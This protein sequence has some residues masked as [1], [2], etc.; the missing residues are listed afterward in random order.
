MLFTELINNIADLYY[1][2]GKGA[3]DAY[4]LWSRDFLNFLHVIFDK[5]F[6]VFLGIAVAVSIL[7]YLISIYGLFAKKKQEDTIPE[8]TLWPSVTVQI[9]TYNELA[10]LNCA[11][12]CLDFE[13]PKEKVQIIMGD[14]SN[15]PEISA[16]IKEFCDANG[17]LVAKRESNVGFKPGNL[18][19]MLKYSTGDILVLFDSD[20]LP[21][22]DFL[23]RIIYPMTKDSS[24]SAVQARWK[25][26][27]PNTN[28]VTILGATM[29]KTF[30]HLI[31]PFVQKSGISFLCGSAEAIKKSVLL[32]L[33]GWKSGSLTEDIECSLRMHINGNKLKYLET[34][35]CECEVPYT[36]K[37]IYKQQMRWAYG[38][39][40]AFKTHLF[41]VLKTK[42]SIPQKLSICIF[43]SGY[44]LSVLLMALFVFGTLSFITHE[45]G[46]ID[47]AKF[48]G[49]FGRNVVLTSGLLFSSLIV[50]LKDREIKRIDKVL[51]SSLSFGLVVTY[52]VNIGIL[53]VMF[54][55]PMKWYMLNK[56]GNDVKPC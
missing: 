21:E 32:E 37:D 54:N 25:I 56:K 33:G 46:P 18:N 24:L 28:L 38:V 8:N 44:F 48:F 17:I 51:A 53:K 23:K 4:T 55:Q 19:N 45:P 2:T 29:S 39:I 14:D 11:Q 49:E 31:M 13:Y 10:A 1:T 5:L 52:F 41:S 36:P 20:F 27:N 6:Y 47:L 9:P 22:K 3:I 7:Y 43:A 34:L 50:V 26:L 15:K 16:K 42:M 12:R 30:H 35:Q 40:S